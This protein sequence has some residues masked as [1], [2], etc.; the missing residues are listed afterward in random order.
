MRKILAILVCEIP[1]SFQCSSPSNFQM[2]GSFI[3]MNSGKIFEHDLLRQIALQNVQRK[4]LLF[5][6]TDMINTLQQR[7]CEI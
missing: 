2:Q 1:R 6:E 3:H 5:S 4:N 7:L